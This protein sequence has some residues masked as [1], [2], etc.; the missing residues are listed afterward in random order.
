MELK[1]LNANGQEGA[2]VSASDVV[3]GRDYNEA[4]IHQVLDHAAPA[5]Q[6]ENEWPLDQRV[7]EQQRDAMPRVAA[8]RI[9]TQPDQS[10]LVDDA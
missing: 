6:V 3:F 4:L 9:V 1:L 2:A 5:P 7:D 8:R 10:R